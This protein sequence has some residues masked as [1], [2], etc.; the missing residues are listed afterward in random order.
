MALHQF[1]NT[2]VSSASTCLLRCHYKH[3]EKRSHRTKA[4]GQSSFQSDSLSAMVK[5]LS[6]F[7]AVT[8]K[9]LEHTKHES[10][11]LLNIDA[12]L[13]GEWTNTEVAERWL[14][15]F[16]GQLAR[17]EFEKQRQ[18][19]LQLISESPALLAEYRHRLGSVKWFIRS[20][21]ELV[22]IKQQDQDCIAEHSTGRSGARFSVELKTNFSPAQLGTDL[23]CR[24][25]N[26][27]QKILSMVAGITQLETWNR[28]FNRLHWRSVRLF[29]S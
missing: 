26:H 23:S 22:L 11:L 7:F 1:R 5:H 16:P 27:S 20:L 8:V 21:E 28:F 25:C 15:L 6:L 18:I 24:D 12:E 19:R 9:S 17:P 2:Q 13:P 14:A 29:A 10:Y 4:S 3:Q